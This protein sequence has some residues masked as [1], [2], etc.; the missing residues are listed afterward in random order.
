MAS[1]YSGRIESQPWSI[2][3][4]NSLHVFMRFHKLS[5]HYGRL[6]HWHGWR[7]KSKKFHTYPLHFLNNYDRSDWQNQPQV[8]EL[9]YHQHNTLHAWLHQCFQVKTKMLQRLLHNGHLCQD[10]KCRLSIFSNS[11]V[12]NLQG[13]LVAF[14]IRHHDASIKNYAVWWL[15]TQLW[16]F[17]LIAGVWA[18]YLRLS[19][20]TFLLPCGYLSHIFGVNKIHG[21]YMH[22]PF[23]SFPM[24]WA[25]SA[26][27]DLRLTWVLD[28]VVCCVR[29]LARHLAWMLDFEIRPSGP[30][31]L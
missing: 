11:S 9:S 29:W 16:R 27:C 4:L 22:E 24:R 30:I 2:F 15:N 10:G 14:K 5:V 12:T 3:H 19:F 18:L 6:S 13:I 20:S 26:S 23:I 31:I 1:F 28:P 25:N 8:L 21:V 7:S 17:V